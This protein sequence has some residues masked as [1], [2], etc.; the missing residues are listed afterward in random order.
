MRQPGTFSTSKYVNWVSRQLN[1]P[2]SIR[3]FHPIFRKYSIIFKWDLNIKSANEAIHF[4]GRSLP[5]IYNYIYIYTY[6]KRAH[7]YSV[8]NKN[9]R[10]YQQKYT[11]NRSFGRRCSE[12]SPFNNSTFFAMFFVVVVVIRPYAFL[13]EFYYYGANRPWGTSLYYFS[14]L[15]VAVRVSIPFL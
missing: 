8:V 13:V 2:G 6:Q 14:G 5:T 15:T 9:V 10:F 1:P 7:S 12:W 3:L 11:P 4:S